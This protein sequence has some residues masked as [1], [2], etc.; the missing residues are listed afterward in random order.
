MKH[1]SFDIIRIADQLD[2]AYWNKRSPGLLNV[3]AEKI[4]LFEYTV[5]FC[6]A[7]YYYF[8]NSNLLSSF[9]ESDYSVFAS[10]LPLLLPL[11][12]IARWQSSCQCRRLKRL[13]FDSWVR[14]IPWR[15]KWQ[16][17]ALCLLRKS[18]WQRILAGYSAWVAKS[19]TRR[20][21]THFLYLIPSL[22]LP[23]F[24]FRYI[25]VIWFPISKKK[26][27]YFILMWKTT[28]PDKPLSY[29]LIVT[30]IF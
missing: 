20:P 29:C 22:L 4:P 5:G 16:P 9:R 28:F 17:T 19:W 26:I 18:R 11:L 2:E 12:W 7:Y 23:P 13:R 10:L 8:F 25:N 30:F 21:C 24:H 1:Q 27:V 3:D 6:L 15:R 14:R